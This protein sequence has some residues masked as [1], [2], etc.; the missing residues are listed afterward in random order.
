MCSD[1][2]AIGSSFSPDLCGPTWCGEYLPLVPQHFRDLHHAL[3]TSMHTTCTQI[4][5]KLTSQHSC[6]RKETYITCLM[7]C[8]ITSQPPIFSDELTKNS[9][10]MFW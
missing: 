1:C 4:Q 7:F 2:M 3:K 5:N 6:S 10:L 9:N 8:V